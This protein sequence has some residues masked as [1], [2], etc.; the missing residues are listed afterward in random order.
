MTCICGL[1]GNGKVWIGGDSAGSTDYSI[2]TFSEPKVWLDGE[3]AYGY[4]D[5]GRYGSVL[6]WGFN[7]PKPPKTQIEKYFA[8]RFV[9][10]LREAFKSDLDAQPSEAGKYPQIEFLMGLRGR[11]YCFG[12]NWEVM[13]CRD[14]FYAVGSGADL[15]MGAM[16]GSA[17]KKPR[18]RIQVALEAASRYTPFVRPPYTI[19]TI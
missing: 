14:G 11:L 9:P 17:D 10:A 15:A 7:P 6:R 13:R 3:F 1:E 2:A 4:C 8:M 19:I 12:S 16:Y 18:E 5:D